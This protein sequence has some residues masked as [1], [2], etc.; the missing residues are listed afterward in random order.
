MSTKPEPIIESCDTG[1]QIPCVDSFQLGIT[2]MSNVRDVPV[3][4]VMVLL[5]YFSMYRA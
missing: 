3:P 1:Q 5:S 4:M 2:W